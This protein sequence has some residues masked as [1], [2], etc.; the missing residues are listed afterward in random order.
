MEKARCHLKFPSLLWVIPEFFFQQRAKLLSL[1]NSDKQNVGSNRFK[2]YLKYISLLF[3]FK[4]GIYILIEKKNA[5]AQKK[6]TIFI[7]NDLIDSMNLKID[8]L[9]LVWFTLI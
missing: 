1:H 9:S 8:D 3:S 5:Y 7:I 4:L 2:I 6:K